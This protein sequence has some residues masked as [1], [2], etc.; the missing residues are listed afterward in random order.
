MPYQCGCSQV[1]I[2][3]KGFDSP[4]C[5]WKN[6]FSLYGKY[7]FCIGSFR[8]NYR[9]VHR[10]QLLKICNQHVP[11]QNSHRVQTVSER[12]IQVRLSSKKWILDSSFA[13]VGWFSTNGPNGQK[14][15]L[16]C[17]PKRLTHGVFSPEKR[18][19]PFRWKVFHFKEFAHQL[20]SRTSQ[21]RCLLSLCPQL[22]QQSI[23]LSTMCCRLAMIP[24]EVFTIYAEYQGIVSVNNFRYP[25]VP[26]NFASSLVFPEK[27]LFCTDTTGS[28]GWPSPAP[29]LQIDDCFEIR[30]CRLG[31]C[32][33]L[34]S[35]HQNIQHEV[36]LPHCVSYSQFLFSRMRVQTLCLPKSSRF[37]V[38]DSK[39]TSWEELACESFVSRNSFI[40]KIFIEFL[41]PLQDL[42]LNG[43]RP[44][45]ANNGFP[46]LTWFPVCLL[47]DFGSLGDAYQNRQ[48]KNVFSTWHKHRWTL[49]K[50]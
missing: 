39:D 37:F 9:C 16:N 27:F 6:K 38:V 4:I 47:L 2:S 13:V 17:C 32:D 33:L 25:R 41:Q 36:R 12:K 45:S 28:I 26:R 19:V 10:F 3:S 14:G 43:A 34:L 11:F 31:P 22:F 18:A 30:N 50:M 7:L 48:Q 20:S 21:Q 46:S 49:G 24:R 8:E 44:E 23:N 40:H 42:N 29:R 35:S 5:D 1:L 15:P